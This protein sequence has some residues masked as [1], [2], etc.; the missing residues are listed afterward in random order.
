MAKELNPY[1]KSSKSIVSDTRAIFSL[2][3]SAGLQESEVSP[4]YVT[5]EGKII[6]NGFIDQNDFLELYLDNDKSI[7]YKVSNGQGLDTKYYVNTDETYQFTGRA[8]SV[9]TEEFMRLDSP[10]K[11]L[12]YRDSVKYDHL[13]KGTRKLIKNSNLPFFFHF[14][15]DNGTRYPLPDITSTWFPPFEVDVNIKPKNIISSA[16]DIIVIKSGEFRSIPVEPTT[17]LINSISYSSGASGNIYIDT[18][19]IPSDVSY[20]TFNSPDSSL[21]YVKIP[22]SGNSNYV[23]DG[24]ISTDSRMIGVFKNGVLA[25]N[26]RSLNSYG[27]SGIYYENSFVV[28]S[29]FRDTCNGYTSLG[30]DVNS[31]VTVDTYHYKSAPVCLYETGSTS[32]SPLL[33]YAIDGNPIYGPYGY[34]SAMD[35]GTSPNLMTPSWRL[36][37]L[38]SRA[39]GPDYSSTYPSGYF[40][41][42]YEYASGIGDLDRYNGR[43]CVTP[44]YP[45]GVYAYFTTVDSSHDPQFPYIIGDKF[46][47]TAETQNWTGVTVGEPLVNVTGQSFGASDFDVD[48]FDDNVFGLKYTTK[49]GLKSETILWVSPHEMLSVTGEFL[50]TGTYQYIA[51]TGQNATYSGNLFSGAG[52][53]VASG[54]TNKFIL[55]KT[56]VSYPSSRN[57]RFGPIEFSGNY[58]YVRVDPDTLTETPLTG[59]SNLSDTNFYTIY[60]GYKTGIQGVKSGAKNPSMQ[61]GNWDGIIPSGTPFKIEVWSFNK[62]VHGFEDSLSVVPSDKTNE[63]VSGKSI[64]FF[65]DFTGQASNQEDAY[66]NMTQQS[67]EFFR[68]QMNNYLISGG[69]IKGNRN[70]Y[71][72]VNFLERRATL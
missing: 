52:N 14:T 56:V 29:G 12:D 19:S 44:E 1:Y 51:K 70:L 55:D 62:S 7:A 47:G 18:L 63:L 53:M 34:T 27:N 42:D 35:S 71:R 45:T 69:V 60:S 59:Y 58:E 22:R 41:Q 48:L 2:T 31:G 8:F 57:Y 30:S 24:S 6:A 3:R 26:Y 13:N 20:G 72:Y 66:T 54:H 65:G 4:I 39:N 28:N 32:H 40:V 50:N 16:S 67:S 64:V 15:H 5:K 23:S 36:K 46:Q 43:T 17:S 9:F 21:K 38:S 49:A 25:L 61:V 10:M 68:R 37:A 33:G 11:A